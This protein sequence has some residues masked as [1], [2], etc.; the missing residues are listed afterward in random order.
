M[1]A[2][3]PVSPDIAH[4]L[5]AHEGF[6]VLEI[7]NDEH[8]APSDVWRWPV[9]A[10]GIDAEMHI[11]YPITQDGLQFDGHYILQ[12]SGCVT[13]PWGDIYSGV[14]DLLSRLREAYA[15]KNPRNRVHTSAQ[16]HAQ[17]DSG[18]AGSL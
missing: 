18:I 6:H 17:A 11:P 12:P 10:W 7:L 14:S 9:I 5:P 2:R 13:G 15:D 3:N 8:G 16:G 1:S 4:L